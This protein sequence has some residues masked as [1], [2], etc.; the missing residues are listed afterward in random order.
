MSFG[1]SLCMLVVLRI[2]VKKPII[3]YEIKIVL[4]KS[5]FGFMATRFSEKQLLS[6]SSGFRK[7]FVCRHFS[8]DL[9]NRLDFSPTIPKPT[10]TKYNTFLYYIKP[11]DKSVMH[12]TSVINE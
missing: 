10:D 2:L 4:N 12:T 11:N 5:L 9:T 8:T 6:S 7:K 1:L 3:F